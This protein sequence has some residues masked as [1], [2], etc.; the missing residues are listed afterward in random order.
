MIETL[1]LLLL[2]SAILAAW[3]NSRRPADDLCAITGMLMLPV[4][5]ALL[6]VCERAYRVTRW[7]VLAYPI[8]IL[9]VLITM[10]VTLH[11]YRA[12]QSR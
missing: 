5:R 12:T 2:V 4:Y 1:W 7:D 9:V 10:E 11:E 3:A 6:W 8:A